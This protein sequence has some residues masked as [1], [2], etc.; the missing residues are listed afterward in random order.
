MASKSTRD[1]QDAKENEPEPLDEWRTGYLQL[2]EDE[3]SSDVEII[4]V[5]SNREASF[6]FDSDDGVDSSSEDSHEF[7]LD[8]EDGEI[9]SGDDLDGNRPFRQ[10]SNRLFEGDAIIQ[11]DGEE[12]AQ[13]YFGDAAD[14][15][16]K[17]A[18]LLQQQEVALAHSV[19]ALDAQSHLIGHYLGIALEETYGAEDEVD[20]DM[21][22]ESLLQLEENLGEV[23]RRHLA[24]DS[25]RNL[26]RLIY[27]LS[28]RGEGRKIG[29]N[30]AICMVEYNEGDRLIRLPCCHLLHEQCLEDWLAVRATCPICRET[31]PEH[32]DL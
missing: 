30:C 18:R 17:Y 9:F 29:V 15:D 5:G 13:E 11:S 7:P 6:C 10:G 26:P 4:S 12:A 32:I 3:G 22:Y 31:V 1:Y 27:T 28:F 14:E 20:L 23:K 19:G 24:V 16:A 8:D 21:S 2:V 25:V